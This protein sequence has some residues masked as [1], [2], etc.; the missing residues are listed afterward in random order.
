ME[1][2]DCLA[3]GLSPRLYRWSGTHYLAFCVIMTSFSY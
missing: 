3:D 2:A 1:T